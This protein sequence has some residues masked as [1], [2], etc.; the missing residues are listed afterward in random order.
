MKHLKDW[1]RAL[2]IAFTIVVVVKVFVFEIFTIP[3]SS[4]EKTLIPG[5]LILVNKLSYGS[6]VPFT[7]YKLPALTS[8][9]RNDVVVF[10]YPM[11]DAATISEKSYYIKR[12]V[13]LPGDT[14]E[15]KNKLVYIN[16][17]KQNF[18]EFAQF[19]YN[20]LSDILAEDTLRKYEINEGGRTFDSQLWQL[21]MTK[22]TKELLEKLPYIKSIK[23]IDIPYNAYADY[24][25]PYHEF[26]RWNINYY[27]KIV[28]PKKGTTVEL[29]SN[30][31]FLYERIIS[32]YEENSLEKYQTKF[33]I[34]G[35]TTNSY[36]FKMD[37]YFMMGDNRH[38]S[39]DSRFWGFAPENHIVGKAQYILFS[40]QETI[41]KKPSV[42]WK[43]IF[44]SIK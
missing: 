32:T 33:I 29:D 39:S 25:F 23:D 9:N 43:R 42:R 26:Y 18:P 24:I 6:A 15:I 34:N 10:F 27:G 3:T 41:D 30:N 17:T 37:Y 19:N 20:V 1:L 7:N 11:D 2:L 12:C 21:T 40:L 14:L 28:I 16:N 44:K 35:D 8:I 22:K 38:N 36:T 13:A 31:I 5:D 4:M